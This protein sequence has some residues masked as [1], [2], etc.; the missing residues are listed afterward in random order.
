MFLKN[1][2]PI[3]LLS[4]GAFAGLVAAGENSAAP[5]PAPPPAARPDS[6][7]AARRALRLQTRSSNRLFPTAWERS[8]PEVIQRFEDDCQRLIAWLKKEHLWKSARDWAE[9]VLETEACNQSPT[10]GAQVHLQI[11]SFTVLLFAQGLLQDHPPFDRETRLRPEVMTKL[12]GI[13]KP[14]AA[15]IAGARLRPKDEIERSR[16]RAN[17]GSCGP[18]LRKKSRRGR[19]PTGKARSHGPRVARGD[20]SGRHGSRPDQGWSRTAQ[21]HHPLFRPVGPSLL[22]Q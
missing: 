22:S 5:D 18:A 10:G 17:S 9:A 15:F 4:G 7:A 14:T 16:R 6:Q 20:G 3:H 11:K 2:T 12:P 1:C 8:A 19:S 13:G 21:G